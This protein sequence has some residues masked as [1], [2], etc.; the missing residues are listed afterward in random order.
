MTERRETHL[1]RTFETPPWKKE[2][3]VIATIGNF[4]G[5]HSGHRAL[6]ERVAQQAKARQAISVAMSFYPH[7]AVRLGK[8]AS[9]PLIT[10]LHQ[11]LIQLGRIDLGYLCLIHFTKEFSELSA[12]QFIDL[13]LI[14]HLNVSKV[15]LGPDACV[16]HNRE[17]TPE[18]IQNYMHNLKRESEIISAVES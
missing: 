16:G 7:P 9:I 12:A 1:F 8:I 18:D 10:S 13:V 5:V 3:T 17:G 4:D 2:D 6:L 11:K 15:I 14:K